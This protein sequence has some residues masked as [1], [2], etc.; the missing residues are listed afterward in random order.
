VVQA[1]QRLGA[2]AVKVVF[3]QSQQRWNSDACHPRWHGLTL[4]GVD[5]VVWRTPD[6]AENQ[7]AFS[8]TKNQYGHTPFPQVRMVCQMELT[9]HM[10][11]G[12]AF[13]GIARMRCN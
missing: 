3:E 6:T 13:E 11:T 4:L 12:S 10:L 5:G 9:S 8:S 1:R 7:S 2:D